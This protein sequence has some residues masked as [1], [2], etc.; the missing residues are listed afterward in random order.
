MLGEDEH[1]V[2]S[3]A[4][5]RQLQGD[6]G[7][8]VIEIEAEATFSDDG[9]EIG[10]RGR[11]QPDVDGDAACVAE[12]LDSPLLEE[13]E[14]LGLKGGGQQFRSRRERGCLGARLR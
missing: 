12:A 14:E 9:L 3:F 1:V 4:E 10:A 6:D 8:A 5:R 7:E 13:R 2:A 11:E